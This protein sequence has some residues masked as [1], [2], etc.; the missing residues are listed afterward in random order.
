MQALLDIASV[1]GIRAATARR[2]IQEQV[3]R[4]E[5]NADELLQEIEAENSELSANHP[6]LAAS[7]GGEMRCVRA[8]AKVVIHDM[9]ARLS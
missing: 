6:G 9:V 1:F 3:S 7:L 5:A 4:I 8:V 2:L